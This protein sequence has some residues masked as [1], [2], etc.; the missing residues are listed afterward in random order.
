[1]PIAPAVRQAVL[2]LTCL[3]AL[4]GRRGLDAAALVAARYWLFEP[5]RLNGDPIPV[6]AALELE[7]R[8]R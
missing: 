4:D 5:A 3:Q 8:L 2:L 7:F 1:M 6:K